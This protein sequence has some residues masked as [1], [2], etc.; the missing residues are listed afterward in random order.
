MQAAIASKQYVPFAPDLVVEIISPS[1]SRKEATEKAQ[2][3]LASGARLVWNIWIDEQRVEVWQVDEPM[4]TL[5]VQ[6]R[7][8]GLEVVPGFSMPVAD[9]FEF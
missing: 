2:T 6:D 4:D 8:D 3:W 1:Q 9:L 7:L 5:S